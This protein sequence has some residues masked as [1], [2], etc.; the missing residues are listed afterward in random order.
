M[1]GHLNL[2]AAC[3]FGH[4]YVISPKIAS[5]EFTKSSI[6]LSFRKQRSKLNSS[7]HPFEAR[8]EQGLPYSR[9]LWKPLGFTVAFSAASFSGAALWQYE[10][11]RTRAIKMVKRPFGWAEEKIYGSIKQGNWRRQVNMWWNG[12]SEGQ[13]LFYPICF[14]NCLVFLAWRVPR[15]QATMVKYFCSN[16]CSKVL[17]WPMVFSTFSHYSVLHLMANMFVL[18]SFS[19]GAVASLGKEQFLGLYLSAGVISSFA[20]YVHKVAIATSSSLSLGAS[21]AIM[22]IL[23]Y[24]CTQHPDTKLAIIF[25]PMYPF[26]AGT[27]IKAI[28]AIDAVGVLMGWRFLDHAAHLGG[29]L[30]GISWAV[31]G[32]KYVWQ[33]REPLVRWWHEVRGTPSD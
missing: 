21:G 23:G 19:S 14:V 11:M 33:K 3:L 5:R 26:S 8:T 12:L 16:P 2:R 4:T 29:A 1:L 32:D 22:A 30:F 25:L 13:R 20:S 6:R 10:N 18:H 31:W 9:S 7:L 17:C 27:A 24:V 15:F 28:I